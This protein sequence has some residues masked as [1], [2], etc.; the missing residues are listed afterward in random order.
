MRSRSVRGCAKCGNDVLVVPAVAADMVA[1]FCT[2]RISICPSNGLIPRETVDPPTDG[3]YRCTSA[4]TVSSPPFTLTFSFTL[5]R[6]KPSPTSIK[7]SGTPFAHDTRALSFTIRTSSS[8]TLCLVRPCTLP[9]VG[10]KWSRPRIESLDG[11]ELTL[12][13]GC[14]LGPARDLGTTADDGAAAHY[15]GRSRRRQQTGQLCIVV[16]GLDDDAP[17]H[18]SCVCRVIL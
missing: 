15:R 18:L 8:C 16:C 6:I 9:F 17:R 1:T 7:F 10:D 2:A 5:A 12:L 13:S 14:C 4:C 11:G 3:D